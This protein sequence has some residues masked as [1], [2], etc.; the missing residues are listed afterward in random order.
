M[1]RQYLSVAEELVSSV[2]RL[3]EEMP[4]H[5]AI[6]EVQIYRRR[7]AVGVVVPVGRRNW[8]FSRRRMRRNN[9]RKTTFQYY[10]K[11]YAKPCAINSHEKGR[12]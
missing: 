12:A 3:V 8:R 1:M 7:A 6:E 9:H 5:F 11:R 10:S 4:S 2:I